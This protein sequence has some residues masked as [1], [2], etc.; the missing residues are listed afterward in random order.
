MNQRKSYI[1][2]WIALLLATVVALGCIVAAL[3]VAYARY[4][5]SDTFDRIFSVRE[6]GTVC[7]GRIN[8]N[9]A[10][11]Q[12]Q[13]NWQTADGITS[14]DFAI[15]NGSDDQNWT[16]VN[17]RSCIRVLAGPGNWEQ[18]LTL[19]VGD[20][21]YTAVPTAILEGSS[22]YRSFGEGWVLQFLDAQG[23]ELSWPL[24]GEGW[25]TIPMKLTLS[26]NLADTSLLR[27][28]VISEDA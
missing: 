28:Q 17:Q 1:S 22:L 18:V 27:L 3:G 21:R 10:F 13:S 6:S 2:P 25:N 7:L 9:G 12:E 23:N 26:A 14:L 24:S 19:T 20:V 8:E 4:R 11:V 5:E 15:S 16:E